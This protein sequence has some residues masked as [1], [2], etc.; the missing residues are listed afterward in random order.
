MTDVLELQA[1]LEELRRAY[2]SG[3]RSVSYEGKNVTYGSGDEMRAAIASLQA[4]IA[5]ATG[6]TLQ[7]IGVVRSSK[8]Y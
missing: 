4:E 3:A 7:T 6:T 1:Q 8:G 5:H 2:R